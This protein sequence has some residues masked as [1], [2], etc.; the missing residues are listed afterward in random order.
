MTLI[1]EA[2]TWLST[3]WEVASL[4]VGGVV[5]F[6]GA[7]I[8]GK[9]RWNTV[10]ERLKVRNT[11][12]GEEPSPQKGLEQQPSSASALQQ[13]VCLLLG[14]GATGKTTLIRRI[15]NDK[16]A[17]P[18]I[19]T[20]LFRLYEHRL[21][22]NQ[23]EYKI[24]LSDYRGQD[25]GVLTGGILDLESASE[26]RRKDICSLLLILDICDTEG[27]VPRIPGAPLP[28]YGHIQAQIEQ[29]RGQSL[30]AV[31][32]LLPKERLRFALILVNKIDLFTTEEANEH[33]PQI[34]NMLDP[35]RGMLEK[36]LPHISIDVIFGSA[37]GASGIDIRDKL[38]HHAVAQES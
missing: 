6:I 11:N 23:R 12:N 7:I 22:Q 19:E 4:G 5:T 36:A 15:T 33:I 35:L 8:L 10:L 29:W 20:S 30:N 1:S 18:E 2:T 37:K 14:Q 3:N 31:L 26:V 32:G 28:D 38:T 17:T 16:K 21:T 13:N 34:R 9:E 25:L 24:I 27:G